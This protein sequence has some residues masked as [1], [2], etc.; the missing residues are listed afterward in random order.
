MQQPLACQGKTKIVSLKDVP[1]QR[2]ESSAFQPD[3]KKPEATQT[4]FE[5]ALSELLPRVRLG[6]A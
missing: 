1:L 5:A 3:Q 2:Y 4:L 6:Y